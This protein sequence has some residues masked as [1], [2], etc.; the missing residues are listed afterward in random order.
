[1]LSMFVDKGGAGPPINTNGFLEL[2][3]VAWITTITTE[4]DQP[5]QV[6]KRE[7]ETGNPPV[8]IAR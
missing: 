3:V 5:Q 8:R 2:L 6:Y 1:M 4:T 7:Q